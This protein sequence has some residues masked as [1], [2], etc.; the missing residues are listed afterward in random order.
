MSTFHPVTCKNDWQYLTYTHNGVKLDEKSGGIADVRWPD[1]TIERDVPFVAET[2]RAWYHDHGNR[3]DVTQYHLMLRVERYGG[4]VSVPLRDSGVE[5][6]NVRQQSNYAYLARAAGCT[7][8]GDAIED[9]A[10]RLK[11]LD[12]VAAMHTEDSEAHAVTRVTVYGFDDEGNHISETMDL[13]GHP[14]MTERAYVAWGVRVHDPP[15]NRGE[16]TLAPGVADQP[17]GEG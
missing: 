10:K 6:A 4:L 12:D 1:G 5:L 9:L 11:L 2:R 14:V 3:S 7:G 13:G 17:R 8:G 15:S 16:V